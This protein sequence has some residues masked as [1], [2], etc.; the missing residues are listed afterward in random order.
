M[1]VSHTCLSRIKSNCQQYEYFKP[2]C[3]T[4]REVH[5]CIVA[6]VVAHFSFI[7]D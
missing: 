5:K 6:F 7:L 2:I 1:D 4:S 3:D